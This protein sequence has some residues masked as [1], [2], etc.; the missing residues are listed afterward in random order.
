M[1]HAGD[2]V[3][4]TDVPGRVLWRVTEVERLGNT[5]GGCEI[6]KLR[7]LDELLP[8]GTVLVRPGG[9]VERVEGFDHV[10]RPA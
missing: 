1:Y 9:A 3:Y 2:Y 7:P 5:A 10:D 4:V 6:L 8:P